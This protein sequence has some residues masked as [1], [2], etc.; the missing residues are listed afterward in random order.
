MNE[1]III[2]A[3]LF[4]SGGEFSKIDDFFKS[5]QIDNKVV[6]YDT[7]GKIV[8]LES[9]DKKSIKIYTEDG[10]CLINIEINSESEKVCNITLFLFAQNKQFYKS[11]SQLVTKELLFYRVGRNIFLKEQ[12]YTNNNGVYLNYS[13]RKVDGKY[14]LQLLFYREIDNPNEVRKKNIEIEWPSL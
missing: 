4:N 2:V 6:V 3:M 12:K 8:S 10:S 14:D 11:I 7:N 5:K 1:L 13:Y 9:S